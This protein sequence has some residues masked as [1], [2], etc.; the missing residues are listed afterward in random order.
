MLGYVNPE[1]SD[2]RFFARGTTGICI[3]AT[4][5]TGMRINKTTPD[6]RHTN[7]PDEASGYA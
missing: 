4:V 5:K 3:S 2:Q 1:L 6:D 7:I